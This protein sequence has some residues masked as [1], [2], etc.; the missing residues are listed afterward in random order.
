[1]ISA[2]KIKRD[3]LPLSTREGGSLLF[4]HWVMFNS[5]RPKELQHA[6]LP[7]PSPSPRVCSDPCPVSWLCHLTPSSALVPFSSCPQSIPASGSFLMSW[8]RALEEFYFFLKKQQQQNA[9]CSKEE[10]EKFSKPSVW[11]SSK[12]RT[13]HLP[14]FLIINSVPGTSLH[15]L[16]WWTL[17]LVFSDWPLSKDFKV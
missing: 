6:R 8:F 13:R 11:F 15:L 4:S 10:P 3:H 17:G 5:L 9:G 2:K 7:C 16:P 14:V 1:M 12:S